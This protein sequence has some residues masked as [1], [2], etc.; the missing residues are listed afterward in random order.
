MKWDQ[1]LT[2]GTPILVAVLGVVAT[3]WGKRLSRRTEEATAR[4]TN[5]EAI[6]IEVET[7]RGLIEDVKK[8]MID[9]RTEYEARAVETRTELDTLVERV[10]LFEVR[11]QVLLAQLTAHQPWDEAAFAALRAT[12]P[13]YPPPPPIDPDT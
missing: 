6:S 7:A 3:I 11:Q 2:I 10:R 13:G 12:T 1:A 9:Q 8:A 4:K 5:A